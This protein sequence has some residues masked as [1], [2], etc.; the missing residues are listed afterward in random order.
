MS[1]GEFYLSMIQALHTELTS[2]TIAA[3]P[4]HF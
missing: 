2:N 4:A 3:G 1:S